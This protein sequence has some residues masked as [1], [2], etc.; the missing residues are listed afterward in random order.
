M[1]EI[2]LPKIVSIG[3]FNAGHII[4]NAVVSKNRKTTMFEIEFPVGEGGISY[5]DNESHLI[6]QNLVI[7]AKPGQI[8]HTRL[9]FKCYYIHIIL[10]EGQ[11]YDILS[12]LPNYLELQ[13]TR[14]IRDIFISLT[15]HYSN[16]VPEDEIILQ[17]LILK[18]IYTLK[19]STPRLEG[20]HKPQ[21]N[22]H[23]IIEKTIQ[24]INKNLTAD[25][26]L[27]ALSQEVK[28]S[29]IYFHKLFKASTGKTLRE[30]VEH[31]RI[32]KA[33]ELLVSTNMT[34]TEISYECGFSSQSYFSYAFKRNK[35]L[36]PREYSNRLLNEYEK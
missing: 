32:K 18:L 22:N 2:E 25:L 14:D 17:S 8:R 4:K 23:A 33:V 30:F 36:S 7:C 28:F 24:Y 3:M 11:L 31:Q 19:K 10:N 16:G 26:S 35:G 1:K 21:A 15:E 6:T 12:T 27:D 5:I 34:L 9:P 13:D 29:K 20:I